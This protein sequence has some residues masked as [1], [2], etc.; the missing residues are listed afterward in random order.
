MPR[1]R[2][3]A[4]SQLKLGIVGV[5][6]VGLA[7]VLIAAVGGQAGFFWELYP[8][9]LQFR[10]VQGLKS[11]AVVRLSGKDV[12]RV[13]AVDFVGELVEVT[14]KVDKDVRPLITN[15]SVASVGALSLLGESFVTIK[16]A[17][18]GISVPDWGYVRTADTGSISSLTE[19]ASTA[20]SDAQKLL[21]DV[22]AGRGTL[23]KLVTDDA[24]Y[25]ELNQFVASAGEVT[26]RLNT[27]KGTAGK[28][29]ND[30]A[31]YDALK[32]SLENLQ[33][34]TA[35]INAGQG[36]LGR[37]LNDEA[38]GKSLSGTMTNLEQTTGRLN[39]GEG[40]MGKLLT[41]RQLYDRLDQVTARVNDIAGGLAGG[42][43][44]AG[45]LLHNKQLYENMN[46]A[47]TELRGLL[48]DIR[49]DPKKF[50]RVSVSIF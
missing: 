8:I 38:M 29:I 16:A 22:R 49:K 7:A 17:P 10:D 50:L 14:C 33:Q 3:I 4:W 5:V 15:G 28:L 25:T 20:M 21:A 6:A 46:H 13:E 41:D 36:A 18:G 45:Q 26:A 34:M 11:G 35:R 32:S 19:T 39:R 24:L 12:G 40:T 47:V 1:T 30:P 23:G 42:E 43:G 37:F 9:K 48:A 27:G 2:S 44:T 31:A